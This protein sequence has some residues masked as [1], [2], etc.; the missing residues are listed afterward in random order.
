MRL[1]K[2]REVSLIFENSCSCMLSAIYFYTNLF[3]S[4]VPGS[5]FRIYNLASLFT[6]R[7][8]ISSLLLDQ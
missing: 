2:S 6:S 7:E 8:A 1:V 5:E 3:H 4:V